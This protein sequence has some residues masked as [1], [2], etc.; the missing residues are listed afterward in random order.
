MAGKLAIDGG[1][2]VRSKPLRGLYPGAMMIGEEEKR[3]VLEVLDSKSLFRFYGPGEPGKVATFEREFAEKMGTKH[4]LAVTSGTAALNVGLQALGVGPG[5]EVI[6]PAYTFIASVDSVVTSRAIPVFAE[7]DKSLGMSPEDFEAKITDRTKAVIPAH[8]QGASA[9]MDEIMDIARKHDLR[10]V[11]DCAQACGASYRG[12]RVGSIGD[13]GA[14]SLQLGK[15]ITC[16]DGGVVATDDGRI[17]ERARRVHDHGDCKGRETVR[18]FISQVYRM[19]ELSGA[20]SLEQLRKLDTLIIPPLRRMK[21][22]AKAGV[23]D[24][25]GIEFRE[26]PDEEGDAGTSLIFYLPTADLAARFREAL[27]AENVTAGRGYRQ[28]VYMRE[29]ILNQRTITDEG[30]PF[31]CPFYGRKIEYR[32]GMCPKTE[33]LIPRIVSIR[34]GPTFTD[35]DCDDI[36]EAVHKVA[37]AI[38]G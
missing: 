6:V 18:P 23:S 17:D 3:A 9:K 33:E 28:P 31:T 19:S 20:V 7:M 26:V 34:I 36:V 16:G 38:L 10:V 8:L 4:A 14:F 35:Q 21:R 11:E 15:L 29:Q 5:D 32:E 13:V 22:R 30:C 25:K 1:K 2:P 24:I 27:N 12:K 37:R